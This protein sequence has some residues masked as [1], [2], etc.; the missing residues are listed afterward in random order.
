M[1]TDV[2]HVLVLPERD[3]AEEVAELLSEQFDLP[4]EPRVLR[5]ALAG[6]D[7]AEDAQWLVIVESDDP[8]DLPAAAALDD[9]ASHHGGWLEEDRDTP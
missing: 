7:D 3:A 5:D 4:D 2:R 1:V 8:D 6:E 9:I